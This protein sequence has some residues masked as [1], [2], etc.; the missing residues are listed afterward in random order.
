MSKHSPG[1]WHWAGDKLMCSTP[2][3]ICCEAVMEIFITSGFGYTA[4]DVVELEWNWNEETAEADRAL[5]ASAPDL[6]Q[7]VAQLE[8]ALREMEG[9]AMERRDRNQRFLRILDLLK[10]VGVERNTNE[11]A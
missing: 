5:I 1:P 11:E 7:R 8:E 4:P 2:V 10:R 9:I 6:F 3:S